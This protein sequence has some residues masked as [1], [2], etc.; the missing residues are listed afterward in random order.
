MSDIS[1]LKEKNNLK[2]LHLFLLGLITSSLYFIV[3]MYKTNAFLEEITKIKTMSSRYFICYLALMGLGGLFVNSANPYVVS[4]GGMMLL[5]S[6]ILGIVWAFRA[7]NAL[8]A[9]T[10]TEHNFELRMK[11]VYTLL[12]TIYYV[13]YCINDLP[14][15]KQKSHEKMQSVE[16][17]IQ[18]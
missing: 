12:F 11:G 13:N 2:T 6:T 1:A 15:A 17:T 9:Y 7:R 18:A 10:L 4:L 5:T 16:K 8:R 3:W 14:N